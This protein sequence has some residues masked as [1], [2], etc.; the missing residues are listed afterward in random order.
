M[1]PFRAV[2]ESRLMPMTSPVLA[3]LLTTALLPGAGALAGVQQRGFLAEAPPAVS[4]RPAASSRLPAAS[5][6]ASFAARPPGPPG[7]GHAARRQA[8]LAPAGS[9]AVWPLSPKPAVLAPFDPPTTAY[10]AGHRGVDLAG[11]PGQQVR[12]AA[13]GRVTYA[14]TLAGRG[15]VVVGHGAT[16]TTYEPVHAV[17]HVGD[18]VDAGSPLGA[19]QRVAGHCAPATCLHWGLIEGET[20]LDPLTLVGQ[21]RVRLLPLLSGATMR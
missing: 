7:V 9:D 17:V 21:R 6:D 15:V 20:Y 5:P 11:A 8:V 1:V 2:A 19:L 12:S 10:G 16:R 3:L 13:P 14:G 4:S 18:R